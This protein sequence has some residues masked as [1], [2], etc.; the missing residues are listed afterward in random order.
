MSRHSEDAVA[1]VDDHAERRADLEGSLPSR[2]W[3]AS[4]GST[5]GALIDRLSDPGAVVVRRGGDR[6]DLGGPRNAGDLERR[7]PL[8]V[9]RTSNHIAASRPDLS[10]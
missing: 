10:R 2:M 6:E 7:A 8:A 9:R 4:N 1:G 5:P 3:S